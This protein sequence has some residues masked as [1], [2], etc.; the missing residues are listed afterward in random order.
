MHIVASASTAVELCTQCIELANLCGI[1]SD[2]TQHFGLQLAAVLNLPPGDV[3]DLIIS[4][5]SRVVMVFGA[6][7]GCMSTIELSVMLDLYRFMLPQT[8][9]RELAHYI[10]ALAERFRQE[11]PKPCP[12]M[13]ELLPIFD[14]ID[15]TAGTEHGNL[16]RNLLFRLASLVVKV[17]GTVT[18]EESAALTTYQ[19]YLFAT[20]TEAPTLQEVRWDIPA[21][22][23]Q[24][25]SATGR[26]PADVLKSES[27][28]HAKAAPQPSRA[29][30][31]LEALLSQLDALVGLEQVKA[32]VGQLA[33]FLQ[34]EQMRKSRG[35]KQS[36]ISLHLVFYGNPGTG[37]TTVA[38]LI[39]DIYHALGFLSRGHLVEV[40]RSQLVGGY[41]GQTAIKTREVIEN[42]K[43][44]VLFIDEAY[45]LVRSESTQDSYGQ[46]AIETLLKYMEDYRDDLVVIAA[47]YPAKMAGFL[48]AN[49]GLKSRFTRFV[50][51]EDYKPE[52]LMAI[53][54]Q[55]A[56]RAQYRL[57]HVAD[58]RLRTV[59]QESYVLRD[60]AFGNGRFVRNLFERVIGTLAERVVLLPNVSDDVLTTIEPEDIPE[61]PAKGTSSGQ[62]RIGFAPAARP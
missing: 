33:R 27:H 2:F 40:D 21:D 53:F 17:D 59:F 51:F 44:G 1:I 20:P 58:A 5:F 45:S 14:R 36:D 55:L 8:G 46:E 3:A 19:Q 12:E 26:P 49:P 13:P 56:N 31:P 48:D 22:G 23:S 42:A 38:R 16:F 30:V 25:H 32:E 41:L 35:L 18:I 9:D 57:S 15:R 11:T 47:G 34:V 7:D 62:V 43:G 4:D 39:A 61:L 29:P 50:R 54:Q 52:Q 60:E 37:K 6:A 10:A 24:H 28:S